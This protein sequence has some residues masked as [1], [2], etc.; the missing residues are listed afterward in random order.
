MVC[1][2]CLREKTT[3]QDKTLS[4]QRFHHIKVTN[5]LFTRYH[6]TRRTTMPVFVTIL[7][8]KCL[9]YEL[10]CNY[11]NPKKEQM[12]SCTEPI[13]AASL[14]Q[15]LIDSNYQSLSKNPAKTNNV[16]NILKRRKTEPNPISVNFYFLN[17]K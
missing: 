7:C 15:K 11:I 4:P 8:K 3:N 12:R 1:S 9:K 6:Q 14:Y 16:S 5:F 10:L 13:I 17:Q 2:V